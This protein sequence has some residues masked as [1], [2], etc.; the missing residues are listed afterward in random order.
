MLWVATLLLLWKGEEKGSNPLRIAAGLVAGLAV[1]TKF[2]SLVLVFAIAGSV[3]IL[4]WES[5]AKIV[6]SVRETLRHGVYYAA[7][8]LASLLPYFGWSWATL[9]GPLAPFFNALA[10]SGVTSPALTY[11]MSLPT[12]DWSRRVAQNHGKG[13]E[14][15]GS[16][17]VC[18]VTYSAGAVP[19]AAQRSKISASCTAFCSDH[20]VNW[21]CQNR[22]QA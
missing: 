15:S 16:A 22:E 20:A 21:A 14:I 8:F 1:L 3:L 5:Q 4:N 17:G 19:S 2:S 7:G 12:L 18:L 10:V 11:L 6:R 9:G 13:E